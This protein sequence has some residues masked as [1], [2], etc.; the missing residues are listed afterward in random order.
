[1]IYEFVVVILV[2]NVIYELVEIIFPIKRMNGIIKSFSLLIMLYA[3]FDYFA[4]LF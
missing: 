1:M 4:K 2:L 3:L